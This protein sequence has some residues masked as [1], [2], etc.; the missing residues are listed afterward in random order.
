MPQILLFES[1]Y[2]R[3]KTQLHARVPDVEAVVWHK[4][5]SLSVAGQPVNSETVQPVAAWLSGDV[6]GGERQTAISTTI[7]ALPSIRWVQTANAGLDHPAYALMNGRGIQF[8]KSG[9]QSIPI[10][11]YVL[12]Y[13]LEH[14][15]DL[16]TRRAA[17]AERKWQG[18]RFGELWKSRWLIFGYG[19][20][21][22]HV[23]RRAKA[24]DSHVTVVRH[25]DA[26]A[27]FADAVVSGDAMS[28]ETVD[29]ALEQADFV[30][31]ALSGHGCNPR[32]GRASVPAE[33][34]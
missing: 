5:H 23:A 16:A 3:I 21:G 6:L 24:F 8:S 25:S 7:A 17:Q 4:D 18:R 29:A 27:D 1:A 13:A 30:V 14:T 10:A 9:S 31:L 19:H 26:P 12:A 33:N 28:G 34:V 22:R 20:I 32:Y 2:E 15:Q 11:E